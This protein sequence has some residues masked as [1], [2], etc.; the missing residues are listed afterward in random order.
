MCASGKERKGKG[1]K[2]SPIGQLATTQAGYP[3]E[4]RTRIGTRFK[5]IFLDNSGY[6]FIVYDYN[7][8]LIIV[9]P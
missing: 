5:K 4:N 8:N 6:P 9:K 3:D 2:P 1:K 7:Q